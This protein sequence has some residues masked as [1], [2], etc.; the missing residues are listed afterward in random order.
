MGKQQ[1]Q[2]T[3]NHNNLNSTN[4]VTTKVKRT[5]RSVPRDSPPQRSSIYRGVT[6]FSLRYYFTFLCRHSL[7]ITYVLYYTTGT[8]GQADMKLICGTR[9]AGM[10]HRTRKD[11]KVS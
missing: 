11:D 8:D 9:I 3:T 4:T 5:R 6:R 7:F 1:R 2:K 10:S